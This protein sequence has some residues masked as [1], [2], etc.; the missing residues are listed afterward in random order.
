MAA[1]NSSKAQVEAP[2]LLPDNQS[3][4]SQ[5][6]EDLTKDC[7]EKSRSVVPYLLENSPEYRELSDVRQQVSHTEPRYRA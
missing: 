6:T 3:N 4:N 5:P 1:V 7:T 2:A